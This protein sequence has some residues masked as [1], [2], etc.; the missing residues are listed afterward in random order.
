MM[1]SADETGKRRL[2]SPA[3][4]FAQKNTKLA[5][6]Y[7]EKALA[8]FRRSRINRGIADTRRTRQ[9]YYDQESYDRALELF[10]K[11]LRL[12]KTLAGKAEIA[13]TLNSI[14]NTYFQQH[15]FDAAIQHYQKALAGFEELNNS[16]SNA[17][18]DPDAVVSTLSNIASAEYSQGSYEAAL[19]YYLRA[20]SLQDTLRD[21]RVGA[22]LRSSIAT[23][24]AAMG[25]FTVALDYLQQGLAVFE[26]LRDKS[27]IA[28]TLSDIG[29]A[30][31]Q[32]RN[33]NLALVTTKRAC[34]SS[35]S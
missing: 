3:R 19:G 9:R 2:S 31:F 14:G 26:Q 4:P 24:Y 17:L 8:E 29:E 6:E 27:K 7:Y 13:A 5:I 23:I 33:Y 25:N 34:R 1:R 35:K 21:K 12:R 32:L 30:Y 15:E 20:L 11:C 22:I 18:K 16:S 10:L 28:G